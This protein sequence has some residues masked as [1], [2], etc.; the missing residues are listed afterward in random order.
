MSVIHCNVMCRTI[1][2]ARVLGGSLSVM[3]FVHGKA[4][5]FNLFIPALDGSTFSQ[6]L[7]ELIH[8]SLSLFLSLAPTLTVLALSVT[9]SPCC[10]LLSL[11]LEYL[12]RMETEEAQEMSQ[13]PGEVCHMAV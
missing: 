11:T 3:G 12:Q 1:T 2:S 7:I 8:L 4:S 13:I 9:W 6:V 5:T 10:P